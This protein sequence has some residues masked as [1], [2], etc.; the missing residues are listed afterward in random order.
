MRISDRPQSVQTKKERV[1]ELIIESRGAQAF[2]TNAT[3]W[4]AHSS[5]FTSSSFSYRNKWRPVGHSVFPQLFVDPFVSLPYFYG[6]SKSKPTSVHWII[7]VGSTQN[8]APMTN[9]KNLRKCAMSLTTNRNNKRGTAETKTSMVLKTKM[10]PR[11][12][13]FLFVQSKKD[14][15]KV[16][17][18][19]SWWTC[20]SS[21]K[22]DK[23]TRYNHRKVKARKIIGDPCVC[24]D[25]VIA[26]RA[27]KRD[28]RIVHWSENPRSCASLYALFAWW[29]KPIVHEH[30]IDGHVQLA[31]V[32]K[33]VDTFELRL[34]DDVMIRKSHHVSIQYGLASSLYW[35]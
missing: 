31:K 28:K 32:R 19:H 9:T 25:G 13:M 12:N 3:T 22:G 34:N 16:G 24:C 14:V 4:S 15:W 33:C 6:Y 17:P 1:R 21:K 23:S 11:F 10:E 20:W 27:Y 8:Y 7:L 18:P 5:S 35:S 30:Q 26:R 2:I 29:K